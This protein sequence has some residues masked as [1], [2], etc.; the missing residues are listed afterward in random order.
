MP[1]H[2]VRDAR[3]FE[4]GK[5]P[6]KKLL[7]KNQK[8]PGAVLTSPIGGRRRGGLRLWEKEGVIQAA[9][10]KEVGLGKPAEE[11]YRCPNQWQ[12]PPTIPK[13]QAEMI[14]DFRLSLSGCKTPA[15]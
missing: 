2:P 9:D 11:T 10:A 6:E 15:L 7:I 8:K 1:Q 5:R 12:C 4:K 3:R 13:T 14:N